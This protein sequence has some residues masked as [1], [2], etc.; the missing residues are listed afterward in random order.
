MHSK[1]ASAKMVTSAGGTA[2][3][4]NA[5]ASNVLARILAGEALGTLCAPA[6]R[7]M[8]ARRRWIGQAARTSGRI[9]VDAGAADALSQG[10]KSLLPSGITAVSGKFARGASVAIVDPAGRQIARGLTNYSSEQLD[11]IKGLKSSQI[12]GVL[13]E[14]PYDEVVHRNNMMLS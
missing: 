11:R 1:L 13:G 8:S 14:K 4:A 3:I 6:R 7:R 5:R 10:G 12:A 2:L 9:F